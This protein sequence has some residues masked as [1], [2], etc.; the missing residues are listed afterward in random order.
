VC[1]RMKKVRVSL[2]SAA[3][4]GLKKV[5]I[6][7]LPTTTYLMTCG[8]CKAG[9]LFCSQ[10]IHPSRLSR[11]WWPEYPVEDV[12]SRITC[13]T[14]RVCIQCLN[15]DIVFEDVL[16]LVELLQG[17]P[18][19]V[20]VQ[21]FSEA[22][23]SELKDR[24]D[25]ISINLDCA[26]PELFQ[27]IKPYYTWNDH[28]SKLLY[29]RDVFGPFKASS[30]LVVGL[31]EAEEEMARMMKFL[32]DHKIYSSL[33][34]FTPVQGTPLETRAKPPIRYYRRMQVAHYLIYEKKRYFEFDK[35]LIVDLDTS[36]PPEAFMTRGCPGC[37]RPYYTET[38]LNL[39]NFPYKPNSDEMNLIRE[40]LRYA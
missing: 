9:C 21:P 40:Q 31:G 26:T 18:I 17:H 35:G 13:S 24:V 34:A 16:N 22:Q 6:D 20:S 2:G 11:I 12:I 5:K 27:K 3:K 14:E 23:I 1:G 30:H 19:S 33:F 39:Y 38:P 28:I 7:C 36:V 32:H 15:Y 25:R 4:L 8:S 37:N 10:Q 29:A